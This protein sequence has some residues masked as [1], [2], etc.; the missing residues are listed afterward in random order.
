MGN[1]QELHQLSYSPMYWLPVNYRLITCR[2]PGDLPA[3]NSLFLFNTVHSHA[4]HRL[5]T[6][7]PVTVSQHNV[8]GKTTAYQVQQTYLARVGF[9]PT[10]ERALQAASSP[11]KYLAI[12]SAAK[13]G[14]LA[15]GS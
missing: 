6:T 11:L 8:M 5:F 14:S 12:L 10:L 3:R 13:L 4:A 7:R 2:R 15:A 9:Q 1:S